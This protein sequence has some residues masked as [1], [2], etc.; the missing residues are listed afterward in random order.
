MSSTLDTRWLSGKESACQ[1]RRHGFR[2]WSGRFP[3]EGNG[4]ALQYP[5]L[6][7]LMDRG[8]WQALVHGVTI[9]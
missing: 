7:N 1:C 3:G 8:A 9:I 6:E 4:Y 5:Y 2:S